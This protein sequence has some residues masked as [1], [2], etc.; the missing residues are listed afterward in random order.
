MTSSRKPAARRGEDSQ[1]LDF[2]NLKSLRR[3]PQQERSKARIQA[4]YN[5]A[6]QIVSENG[7]QAL[8][9]KAVAEKASVPVDAVYQF[10]ENEA[11]IMNTI[12]EQRNSSFAIVLA[13]MRTMVQSHDWREI[14]DLVFE[15]MVQR[16]RS[17]RAYVAIWTGHYLST[18]MEN[19]DQDNIEA[20]ASL[21]QLVMSRQ[22]G[23]LDSVELT[24]ACRAAT[25]SASALLQLAFRLNPNGDPDT[26]TEAKRMVLLYLNDVSKDPQYRES[27]G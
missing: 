7:V 25:T 6:V 20:M 18:Q 13:E 11:A 12:A 24:V 4:M 16:S 8:N 2:D 10:F 5:A 19:E 22:E 1:E 21:L 17:N 15:R 9:M 3:I 26:L 23:L 27:F 14:L